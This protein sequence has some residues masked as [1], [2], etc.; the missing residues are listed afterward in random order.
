MD[1][2]CAMLY[3]SKVS[4]LERVLLLL[5]LLSLVVTVTVGAKRH[6]PRPAG[7]KSKPWYRGKE[8]L[9]NLF[10]QKKDLPKAP[11]LDYSQDCILCHNKYYDKWWNSGHSTSYNT[12]FFQ[13]AWQHYREWWLYET[14]ERRKVQSQGKIDGTIKRGMDENPE[15]AL[16]ISQ[17]DCLSCHAPA[18]NAT[19]KYTDSLELRN[20]LLAMRDG[21]VPNWQDVIGGIIDKDLQF[22]YGTTYFDQVT[23][24]PSLDLTT[25]T[26][27]R[28]MQRIS[29]LTKDGI[30][31]DFCHT[32]TRLSHVSDRGDSLHRMQNINYSLNFEHRF[33]MKKWGPIEEAP[34]A[35]HTIQYSPIY[36]QSEFCAS[37]HQEVNDFGVKV[38]DTYNEWKYS[39]WARKGVTC[40]SCHMPEYRSVVSK[41]GQIRD[42]AHNHSLLGVSDPAFL[43]TAADIE[44]EAV[45]QADYVDLTVRIINNGTGHALPTGI[46]FRRLVLVVRAKDELGNMFW[47]ARQIDVNDA[48]IDSLPDD[49][50]KAKGEY[51]TF[52]RTVG[53]NY[54]NIFEDTDEVPYWMADTVIEDTR[55]QPNETR[56]LK[57]RVPVA[58]Q[59]GAVYMTS[60][61]FY[62]RASAKYGEYFD[63]VDPPEIIAGMG[64]TVQ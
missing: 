15:W 27:I 36:K 53:A 61:L 11:L 25:R 50:W 41:H 47:D 32:V 12:A 19:I 56:E 20:L 10:I 31:C 60:Q 22:D 30:S 9:E 35:S 24:D 48:V 2:R 55:I 4:A 23:N 54:P 62:R 40:Q 5:F 51:P 34:T 3:S 39:E 33:G 49:F 6:D 64:I 37:C 45:R 13:D 1:E 58:D 29:D 44:M 17:T 42:D 8:N 59:P 57:F 63:L 14:N 38:Q 26:Q 21:Y 52:S 18:I 28:F 46:P 16:E 7:D 43:T